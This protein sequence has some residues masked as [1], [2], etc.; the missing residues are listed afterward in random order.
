MMVRIGIVTFAMLT[1]SPEPNRV[2][3]LSELEKYIERDNSLRGKK[4]RDVNELVASKKIFRS[5]KDD[6]RPPQMCFKHRGFDPYSKFKVVNCFKVKDA[7]TIE[8]FKNTQ[9]GRAQNEYHLIIDAK[10]IK[11]TVKRSYRAE[12]LYEFFK[13]LFQ[14]INGTLIEL[15]SSDSRIN[16]D[17][18]FV[19]KKLDLSSFGLQII[20]TYASSHK[21][22]TRE[23][24]RK[25]DSLYKE[26]YGSSQTALEDFS[27]DVIDTEEYHNKFDKKNQGVRGFSESM[28]QEVY[29]LSSKEICKRLNFREKE[30]PNYK[31]F[32]PFS[33]IFFVVNFTLRK[34]LRQ[35]Y[36]PAKIKCVIEA[37]YTKISSYDYI[38]VIL[39]HNFDIGTIT[40]IKIHLFQM[41][42]FNQ[43]KFK[44]TLLQQSLT[45]LLNNYLPEWTLEI[46]ENGFGINQA[47]DVYR[48]DLILKCMSGCTGKSTIARLLSFA[49][50]FSNYICLDSFPT[51]K[52][53]QS[54]IYFLSKFK[55]QVVI[56]DLVRATFG[57]IDP[58]AIK[59]KSRTKSKRR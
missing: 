6:E 55:R 7:K 59:K 51:E 30:L 29:K 21:N 23:I 10:Y 28:I 9:H 49:L 44:V 53:R 36:S 32:S 16:F 58:E 33:G 26:S 1:K 31:I 15:E 35:K 2:Y 11:I 8:K 48:R 3:I 34:N 47:K 25:F 38:P 52:R 56:F 4:F 27:V 18:D 57:R 12:R 41:E 37:F 45:S 20:K 24:I 13:N 17:A 54:I 42:F 19:K 50:G 43:Q 46:F 14:F 40:G 39:S 5:L 22:R